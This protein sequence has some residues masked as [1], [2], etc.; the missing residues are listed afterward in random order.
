MA[1]FD[2]GHCLQ[3]RNHGSDIIKANLCNFQNLTV[4]SDSNWLPVRTFGSH[5]RW[6]VGNCVLC[7]W[8]VSIRAPGQFPGTGPWRT[9]LIRGNG[10]E[11]DVNMQRIGEI[12]NL[13]IN[14]V[15]VSLSP[16]LSDDYVWSRWCRSG[17]DCCFSGNVCCNW[18]CDSRLGLCR[19]HDRHLCWGIT[20][21]QLACCENSHPRK[22]KQSDHHCSNNRHSAIDD[23]RF[24]A[25]GATGAE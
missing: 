13:I 14:R 7:E 17:W 10:V 5:L 11:E 12:M 25:E 18:E 16:D 23:L 1:I 6:T 3:T 2:I 21:K 22:A 9:C 24:E 8:R 15:E 20:T 4:S 19:C